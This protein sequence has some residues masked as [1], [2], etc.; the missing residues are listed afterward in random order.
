MNE[1][2]DKLCDKWRPMLNH[3][4]K[5]SPWTTGGELAWLAEMA[6]TKKLIAEIGSYKGKSTKAMAWNSPAIIHCIDTFERGSRTEFEANLK[7]EFDTEKMYIHNLTSSLAAKKLNHLRFD[8]IFIDADHDEESVKTDIQSWLPLLAENGLFCG[9]DC[10]PE[11]SN[12]GVHKALT[13]LKI[14]Y[15]IAVDSIWKKL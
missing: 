14:P 10:W 8:M 15:E 13:E 3:C 4:E 2:R 9:H 1:Y 11:D 7:K 6:S 12:N 5:L